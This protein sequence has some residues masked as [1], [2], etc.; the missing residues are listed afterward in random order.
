MHDLQH[1]SDASKPIASCKDPGMD[2]SDPI[3]V[4]VTVAHHTPAAICKATHVDEF[5]QQE[6]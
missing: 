3:N 5:A 2:P 1:A 6:E 4:T